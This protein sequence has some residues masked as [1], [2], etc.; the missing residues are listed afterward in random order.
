MINELGKPLTKDDLELRVGTCSAKGF[1]LLLYKTAR[2]D[3]NRLNEVCGLGWSN[4]H[5]VDTK[6]SVTCSIKVYDKDLGLWVE[7]EDTGTESNTE[8]EKGSYSDSFKRAG[9]RFGIGIELYKS[10]F[11]W[12][13]GRVKDSGRKDKY[14][15]PVYVPDFFTSS[16]KITDYEVKD[17]VPHL[18]IKLNNDVLFSNMGNKVSKAEVKHEHVT[19]DWKVIEDRINKAV[20]S[21]AKLETIIDTFDSD[22]GSLSKGAIAKIKEIHFNIVDLKKYHPL[23]DES[24]GDR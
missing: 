8:K 12:V 24:A 21:N 3:V 1:S 4:N 19:L 14:Q 6:G 13:K 16:L 23:E 18:T 5:K 9:F 22:Y 2:T 15:K 20:N 11:I 17:G 7:R 10:P